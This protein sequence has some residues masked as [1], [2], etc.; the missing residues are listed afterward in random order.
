MIFF[1]SFPTIS[2]DETKSGYV[3]KIP[4]LYVSK[5]FGIRRLTFKTIEILWQRFVDKQEIKR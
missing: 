2:G 1:Y 5:Y 3:K 4:V